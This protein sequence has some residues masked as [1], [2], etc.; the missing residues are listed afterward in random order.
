VGSLLPP[1]GSQGT[2]SGSQAWQQMPLPVELPGTLDFG[3][4]YL[5]F[6]V[7]IS[8]TDT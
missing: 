4:I 1:C 7:T 2:N 8:G 6:G 5:V 3:F